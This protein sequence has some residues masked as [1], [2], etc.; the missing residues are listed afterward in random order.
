MAFSKK[1]EQ[2]LEF[3]LT[4]YNAVIC[5]G[6]VRSGKSSVISIAYVL[7]AMNNFHNKNFIIAAQSISSADRNII[8]PLLSI[9]YVH[10]HF[11]VKWMPS[12]NLLILARGKTINN[13]Y[14]FGGKDE[15]SFQTVQGITAAGAFMDEVALMPESFV[16]Q[17]LARCSVEGAKYWFSCNP[18]SPNHWFYQ[19]WVKKSD[20]KNALYLHFTMDDNPSLSEAVKQRYQTMYTGVF[21]DRYIL[22]RWVKA[23]GIIYRKFADNNKKYIL[24]QIPD[25]IIMVNVGVDFGGNK[26]ATT[27]VAVGFSKG[28]HKVYI[29]E[30]ERHHYDMTPNEM[31]EIFVK[32]SHMVFE[33]YNT[34]FTTRADNAEPILIRGLKNAALR[35]QCRTN[36]KPALKKSVLSRIKLVNKL[37]GLERFYIMEHCKT[38]IEALNTAVWD[39]KKMDVRLDD[40]VTSDIDTLDAMEYAM[41]EHM[42]V[43]V[44]I[45]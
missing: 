28:M 11:N 9:D 16:N 19:N 32:F 23:E 10:Q 43:L 3:G 34:A 26:S 25:D 12:M 35:E 44:D 4:D 20:V 13:F 1:Q 5:D 30:A 17:V 15:S 18:E 37:M 41:E 8:K 2:V 31:D 14:I 45:E 29:L 33:K 38:V 22:G 6:S 7:W 24:N 40:L 36:V 27:F 39:D 42:K 21:Y